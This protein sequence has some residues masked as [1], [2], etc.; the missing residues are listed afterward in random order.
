[1]REPTGSTRDYEVDDSFTGPDGGVDRA[2]GWIRVI[3]T[4]HGVLVRAKLETL[5]NLTCSRSIGDFKHRSVLIMEEESF[6]TVDPV[7]DRKTDPPEEAEGVINLDAHHVLDMREVV[8]QYVLTDSSSQSP[9]MA[10]VYT[11]MFA[12]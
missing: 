11:L 3:R 12:C 7:T 8:R 9:S 1:M 10:E 5:V 2:Q 6:P 4:H